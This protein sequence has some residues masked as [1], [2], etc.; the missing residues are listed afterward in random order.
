MYLLTILVVFLIACLK[1]TA[2][3]N[4]LTTEKCEN[5]KT[6]IEVFPKEYYMMQNKQNSCLGK[7]QV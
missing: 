5:P 3:E 1:C 7:C 4:L 6:V 2:S